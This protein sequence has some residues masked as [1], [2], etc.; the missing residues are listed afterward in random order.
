MGR[1]VASG[2]DNL[3]NH[4]D[5]NEPGYIMVFGWVAPRAVYGTGISR[6]VRR[7]TDGAGTLVEM[8]NPLLQNIGN[9]PIYEYE[10]T[11]NTFSNRVFGYTDRYAD[12]M[13]LP[14]K[15]FG[16]LRDG[17]NMDMFALQR[18]F[19]RSHAV[20]ISSDFLQ[21]KPNA[22]NNILAYSED[23]TYNVAIVSAAFDYKVVQPLAE[24]SI[25]S[26]QD[27]A[28]EHGQNVVVHRGGL[29]MS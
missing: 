19:D 3:I 26:L 12:F 16:E 25:P 24:Y 23:E 18:S 5:I 14:D 1:A 22:L 13:T 11:G 4:F 8:A 20:T 17:G 9:Q 27:P 29:R 21:I 15:V 10:L 2:A 7:Y 6:L 28:Y